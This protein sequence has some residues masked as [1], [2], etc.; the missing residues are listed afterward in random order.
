MIKID[1]FWAIA[2]YLIFT[3]CIAIGYWIFYNSNKGEM[4]LT[5]PE[6]VEQ[7]PYCTHLYV[8]FSSETTKICPRCHSYHEPSEKAAKDNNHVP[9]A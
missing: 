7:C 9:P 8:D 2:I 5:R 6:N 1:L 4:D 3:L